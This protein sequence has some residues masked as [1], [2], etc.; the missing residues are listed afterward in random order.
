MITREA[1]TWTCSQCGAFTPVLREGACVQ[2]CEDNQA[3][4]DAHNAA[5][6][7]WEKLTEAERERRI[8]AAGRT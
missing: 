6:D 4:L 7:A 8:R 3:R 1:R 5:F 2:C